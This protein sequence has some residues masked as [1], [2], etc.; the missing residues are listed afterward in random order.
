MGPPSSR[1][2]HQKIPILMKPKPQT[3]QAMLYNRDQQFWNKPGRCAIPP[4]SL[5][6]LELGL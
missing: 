5:D 1:N 3:V 2:R 6:D 4:T